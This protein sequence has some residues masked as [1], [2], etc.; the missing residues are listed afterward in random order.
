MGSQSQ[1]NKEFVVQKQTNNTNQNTSNE[2]NEN[3]SPESKTPIT[4]SEKQNDQRIVD[5]ELFFK[6]LKTSVGLNICN[7]KQSSK[8]I[9]TITDC[10]NQ[11]TINVNNMSSTFISHQEF[12]MLQL[13]MQLSYD[14]NMNSDNISDKLKD[15][16]Q[17]TSD[18]LVRQ[19]L[20]PNEP[21][22]MWRVNDTFV[23]Y[24]PKIQNI[25]QL[26]TKKELKKVISEVE[27]ILPESTL[28]KSDR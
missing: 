6:N 18:S 26:P 11:H 17:A 14:T 25:A 27:S 8:V 15:V 4:E 13:P 22:L 16:A 1:T 24:T 23:E 9:S 3:V 5:C 2:L 28:K 10:L 19:F 7:K 21:E 20:V 12:T